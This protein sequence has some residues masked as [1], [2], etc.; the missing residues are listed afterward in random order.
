MYSHIHTYTHMY[1]N[2]FRLPFEL[3]YDCPETQAG[4]KQE[5]VSD[6]GSQGSAST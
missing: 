3:R 5:G 4:L 6:L 1:A 2:I